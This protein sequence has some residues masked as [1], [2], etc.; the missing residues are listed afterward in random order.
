MNNFQVWFPLDLSIEI[1]SL[2][3]TSTLYVVMSQAEEGSITPLDKPNK[4]NPPD[5]FVFSMS[6]IQ[7]T[8]VL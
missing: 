2:D 1:K 7:Q 8:R 5:M 6:Y 3:R 4:H